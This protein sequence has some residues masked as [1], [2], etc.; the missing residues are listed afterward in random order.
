MI[1][2]AIHALNR[3]NR[4]SV[5]RTID[6]NEFRRFEKEVANAHLGPL[7]DLKDEITE[8]GWCNDHP[9]YLFMASVTSSSATVIEASPISDERIQIAVR[10]LRLCVKNRP[11]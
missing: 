1:E 3:L 7:V 4:P 8:R 11:D 6:I 2:P 9:R 10:Y 5:G